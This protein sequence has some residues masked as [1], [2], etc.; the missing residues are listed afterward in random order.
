MQYD[1]TQHIP[2][3]TKCFMTDPK[4]IAQLLEDWEF[5]PGTIGVRLVS[6]ANRD[7]IQ[8]RVE[9]GVLQMETTDRPDGSRPGGMATYLDFLIAE[10]IN[11]G[12]NWR[13]GVE[14]STEIDREFMQFYQRRISWLKLKEYANVVRDANHTLALMD[15]CEEYSPDESWGMSHE[16]YRP[17]VLFHR[18]QA[19]ALQALQATTP[20]NAIERI[21]AGLTCIQEVFEQH[22]I[23]EHF[24][25]DE[26]VNQL[27]ETRE[28]LR[29]EYKIGMTLTE[30]LEQAIH[31]E[32]YELA[33]ELRDQI[34][35][36]ASPPTNL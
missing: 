17:F 31:N 2:S 13:L 14:H 20:E 5:K 21:N 29:A 34:G 32:Q 24:E 25:G 8:M 16:Q 1:D 3:T 30:Q 4:D 7:M 36:S 27:R 9:M 23:M 33:A 18:T 35:T 10:R 12:E 28:S 22:E 6:L 15:F 26:L 19:D 11:G